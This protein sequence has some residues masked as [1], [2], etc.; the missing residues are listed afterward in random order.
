MNEI[1]QQILNFLSSTIN[2]GND[3]DLCFFR[4]SVLFSFIIRSSSLQSLSDLYQQRIMDRFPPPL[5]PGLVPTTYA[6]APCRDGPTLLPLPS[7]QLDHRPRSR[8][9]LGEK[10]RVEMIPETTNPE[11]TTLFPITGE[12]VSIDGNTYR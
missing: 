8:T 6:L 5:P 9:V 2:I 4:S 3:R 7:V 11:V 10:I 12:H 1:F